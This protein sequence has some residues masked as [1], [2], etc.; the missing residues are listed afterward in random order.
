MVI[1]LLMDS[2]IL[3]I[4]IVWEWRVLRNERDTFSLLDWGFITSMDTFTR[5]FFWNCPSL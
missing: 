5:Y 1:L 4:D 2:A 3:I